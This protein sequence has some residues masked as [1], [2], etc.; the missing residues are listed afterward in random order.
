ME[1]SNMGQEAEIEFIFTFINI[2]SWA[3]GLDE[4]NAI[5]LKIQ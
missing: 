4:I 3:F 2:S 5:S 1:G